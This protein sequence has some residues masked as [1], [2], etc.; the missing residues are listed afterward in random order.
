LKGEEILSHAFDGVAVFPLPFKGEAMC[1]H[2]FDGVAVFPL[3]FKGRVGVGMGLYFTL[4]HD[5]LT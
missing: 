2:A 4:I 5:A 1:S 3:P